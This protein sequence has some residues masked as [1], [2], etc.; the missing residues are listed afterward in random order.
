[1][2]CAG[3]ALCGSPEVWCSDLPSS[4]TAICIAHLSN[5]LVLPSN[6]NQVRE[7]VVCADPRCGKT[8]HQ[9]AYTQYF[10]NTRASGYVGW[11]V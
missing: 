9:H 5:L 8:T 10:Y 4:N 6:P 3:A 2:L 11:S 7:A 1:M